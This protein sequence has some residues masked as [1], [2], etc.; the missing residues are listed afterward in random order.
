M[1]AKLYITDDNPRR[2]DPATIRAQIREACPGGIEIGDRRKAIGTAIR[3]LAPGDVLVIAGKGHEQ[4]QILA[5]E[6]IPFNDAEAARAAV[7]ELDG[8]GEA[9]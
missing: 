9:A 4:G 8:S 6:T 1:P 3:E 5:T 7:K 2:E